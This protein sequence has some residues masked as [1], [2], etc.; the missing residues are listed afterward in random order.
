[1]RTPPPQCHVWC[2]FPRPFLPPAAAALSAEA[3]QRK[4]SLQQAE[5]RLNQLQ[6]NLQSEAEA[7][8][9]GDDDLK[10]DL[11]S[12]E[13]ARKAKD[14]QLEAD[15]E[16]RERRLE[17]RLAE[18]TRASSSR[19][20]SCFCDPPSPPSLRSPLTLSSCLLPISATT[21]LPT[22]RVRL[23]HLVGRA[24]REDGR[25]SPRAAGC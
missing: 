24:P 22:C 13:E 21:A 18:Q 6:G 9:A 3:E 8:K 1:M 23:P 12:E 2:C 14:A 19:S 17:Q 10:G 4:T 20:P 11:E 5:Q 15:A 16:E 7:R 25:R